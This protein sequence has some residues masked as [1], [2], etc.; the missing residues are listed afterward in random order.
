MKNLITYIVILIGFQ[1]AT[2]QEFIQNDSYT[3]TQAIQ[4][5]GEEYPPYTIQLMKA[6]EVDEK[7]TAFVLEDTELLE[8]IFISTLEN[9]G[10]EGVEEIIKVEVEYLACC[11]HVEAR[12]FIL[13]ET[14]DCIALP[15]LENVYCEIGAADEQYIFPN[16]EYGIQGN[17]LRTE[18]KYTSEAIVKYVSL[19]QSFAW[20]DNQDTTPETIVSSFNE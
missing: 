2:A 14:N 18:K 13:T 3:I 12:Y 4:N 5:K 8:G 17:I 16:Q 9:P 19:Q 11:A 1:I 20:N 7:I 10:L 6:G 15:M